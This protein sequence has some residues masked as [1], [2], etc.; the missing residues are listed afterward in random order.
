MKDN[1]LHLHEAQLVTLL[2]ASTRATSRDNTFFFA[3]WQQELGSVQNMRTRI[4]Y[5]M[6]S[7]RTHRH[8]NPPARGR[9]V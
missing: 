8:H 5:G 6:I 3:N 9:E 7:A 4:E 2:M 1:K